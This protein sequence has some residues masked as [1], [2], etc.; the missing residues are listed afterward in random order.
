MP[1]TAVSRAFRARLP[2]VNPE[3]LFSLGVWED[4]LNFIFAYAK[5]TI[6]ITPEFP[7][8]LSD[9]PLTVNLAELY[10]AKAYEDFNYKSAEKTLSVVSRCSITMD[11]SDEPRLKVPDLGLD[12]YEYKGLTV[13]SLKGAVALDSFGKEKR[14]PAKWKMNVGKFLEVV[15]A[16]ET[17]LHKRGSPFQCRARFGVD[18]KFAEIDV[19]AF[20]ADHTLWPDLRKD[21]SRWRLAH[22]YVSPR[23]LIRFK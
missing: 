21:G 13:V 11:S 16:V 7:N 17:V 9:H 22:P 23:F 6:G 2:L 5:T 10:F 3:T 4:V 1:N 20:F 18:L 19:R 15:G 12:F 8:Q 14:P